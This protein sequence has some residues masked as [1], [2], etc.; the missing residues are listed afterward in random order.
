M[1]NR[2]DRPHQ[3]RG[4]VEGPGWSAFGSYRH[5]RALRL[6]IPGVGSMMASE[7]GN[8]S[9]G[10]PDSCAWR[11]CSRGTQKRITLGDAAGTEDRRPKRSNAMALVLVRRELAATTTVTLGAADP[12]A[13]RCEALPCAT[14]AVHRVVVMVTTARLTRNRRLACR[15]PRAAAQ[16]GMNCVF[17][18]AEA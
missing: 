12:P 3:G 2:S 7:Q 1:S 6:V 10:S 17:S 9:S 13:S 16:D 11:S 8:R 4:Q 14:D 18:H 15:S 5:Q